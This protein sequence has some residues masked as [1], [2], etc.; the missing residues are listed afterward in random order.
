M[1]RKTLPYTIRNDLMQRR[2]G[3]SNASFW[4]TSIGMNCDKNNDELA[5]FYRIMCYCSVSS[6]TSI[7][8][9]LL[10]MGYTLC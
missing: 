5:T 8:V 7:P 1:Q 2:G 9:Y 10:I 3:V 6:I 4:E